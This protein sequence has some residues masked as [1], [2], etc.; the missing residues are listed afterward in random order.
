VDLA[1]WYQELRRRRVIRALLGWGLLSFA[2]LQVIEP[3]MHALDLKDWVLKVVVGVLAAGFPVAAILSWFFDLGLGG[4]SRTPD[5]PSGGTDAPRAPVRKGALVGLVLVAAIVGAGVAILA[6]GWMN[7]PPDVAPS[8]AV[9]PFADMSQQHDQ[10]YFADGIAEEILNALA[11][12]EGLRVAG[13]TSSFAFKGKHEDLAEIAKKLRVGA[14]LEGSVR[15]DGSRVR[16]TAQ[17][18]DA[19]GGFHLWSQTFERDLTGIFAVQDEIAR[20]VVA[21]LKGR[22][23][24]MGTAAPP[25]VRPTTSPEAYAK[26]LLGRHF[27]GLD[28]PTGMRQAVKALEEC[29]ALDP[30]YAPAWASLSYALH[31][32]VQ[33]DGTPDEEGEFIAR[34]IRAADRAVELAPSLPDGYAMRGFLRSGAPRWDWRGGE[35]DMDHALSL[36]LADPSLLRLNA[37]WVMA[38][39][40]RLREA[41][42]ILQRIVERD[43]LA[44]SSWTSLAI[45]LAFQ[46]RDEEAIAAIRRGLE[47]APANPIAQAS[48]CSMLAAKG[49]GGEA[50]A[51]SRVIQVEGWRLFAEARALQALGDRAGADRAIGEL[52]AK[53]GGSFA[54]QVAALHGWQGDVDAAFIWLDRAFAQQDS[55]LAELLVARSFRALRGDPR[56]RALLAR[57]N[58]PA[59]AVVR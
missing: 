18:I 9:L 7:R 3:V 32:A 29:L 33:F 6:L 41:V 37:R 25:A 30:R 19:A 47:I 43:P 49:L 11:Q 35:A 20:A 53:E 36:G 17:L 1:A 24:T 46:G 4:V 10:E 42:S 52:A 31:W 8:V 39:Q 23:L 54:H 5:S 14:V 45:L 12:V 13:R 28:N 57:M 56:Y 26:Y 22:L 58:L 2:V 27:I 48:L 55:G 40:G 59:D 15:K 51:H 44:A 38:G 50:L 34:A 16:V 21:A